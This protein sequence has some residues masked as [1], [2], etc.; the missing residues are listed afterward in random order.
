[1]MIH[2]NFIGRGI[3]TSFI[4]VWDKSFNQI[5]YPDG[6]PYIRE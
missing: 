3:W 2:K 1:M 6:D 4:Y 5:N